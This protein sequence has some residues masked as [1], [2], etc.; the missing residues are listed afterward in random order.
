MYSELSRIISRSGVR[1]ARGLIR[2]L[3]CCE[4]HR[5]VFAVGRTFSQRKF[6]VGTTVDQRATQPVLGPI[7]ALSAVDDDDDLEDYMSPFVPSSLDL[8]LGES[9]VWDDPPDEDDDEAP[10]LEEESGK[11][12]D[13]IVAPAR[14]SAVEMLMDFDPQ[15][16]PVSN[17]PTDLQLWLECEAQQEAVIRY[18][19]VLDSARQRK[20]YQSLSMLQRQVLKWFEPLTEEIAARQKEY[21]LKTK[22]RKTQNRYGPY[23]CMLT[24]EKLAVI[25]AH[26][27]I[28]CALLKSG[29]NGKEGVP[30]V[31]MAKRLGEAVEEEFLIHQLLHKRFREDGEPSNSGEDGDE[32]SSASEVEEVE[33]EEDE[34]DPLQRVT[35]KWIY[36]SS[37]LNKYFDEISRYQP[38]VKKRR[39]VSYAIQRAR[40]ILTQNEKWSQSDKIQLGAALFQ[41]LLKKATI[42]HDGK[43]EMAFSYGSRWHQKHKL[44]S[45]V[46]LN[47]KLYNM[48][49]SD[50]LKSFAASTTRHKPMIQTPK[51]WKAPNDGGYLWLKVDLMRYHGSQTQEEALE[52]ADL[53]LLYDGLNS[54]GRVAWQIN[55]E[56]LQVANKCWEESF[57]LGDIP[58]RSDFE[59]PPEPV[60]PDRPLEMDRDS[61]QFE[62]MVAEK[63]LYRD[64]MRKHKRIKQK[65]MVRRT[66]LF[67]P[68]PLE[69]F[70]HSIFPLFQDLRSL[71]C[72]AMLKLDQ[73]EK[74]KE[75]E[76][77]YFPYNVVCL[78]LL[79]APPPL[80]HF[81]HSF[82]PLFPGFSWSSLPS[83]TSLIK[84][85]F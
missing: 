81:A 50:Q 48:L 47:E 35:Q 25:V 38:S 6:H 64:A 85:W 17:D 70:A 59:V 54:L 58:S 60:A 77:L 2:S 73:A 57:P 39:L 24:P 53:T 13:Q 8:E 61:P 82:F 3:G 67:A 56:V 10:M 30:F 41:I 31:T 63:R 19:N 27:A 40:Q 55:K 44:K 32:E 76:K 69:N 9:S 43:E 37:H 80:E 45:Y 83:P 26:E 52:N 79:F 4:E 62:A 71:R 33:E 11:E 34:D 22:K 16:P 42:T 72:S 65:N 29:L 21:I 78:T 1:R 12:V 23:L 18:Q 7:Q 74:F 46:T 51:P 84:R 20:D 28:M 15:N 75:F 68:P 49:V 36:S 66:L 5:H 14:H